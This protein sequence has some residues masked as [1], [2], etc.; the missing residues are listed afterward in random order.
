M[1]KRMTKANLSA[2]VLPDDLGPA[3]GGQQGIIGQ[4]GFNAFGGFVI[5]DVLRELIGKRGRSIFREM[6]DNDSTC[7]ALLFAF[8]TLM[9]SADWTFQA[10]DES[11]A[12]AE[13]QAFAEDVLFG[14][15]DGMDF[16][17]SD[18]LTEAASFLP[19]GWSLQEIIWKRRESDNRIGIKKLA[20]R[21][22]ESIWQWK[23]DDKGPNPTWEVLSAIQQ[24]PSGTLIDLP[25]TKCVHFKT[26]PASGNPEGRSVLR[27]AYRSWSMKK[28]IENIEGIGLERDL[29]GLPMLLVPGAMMAADAD[30]IQKN[31]LTAYKALVRRIRRDSQEGIIL[32][33]NRDQGG[34]LLFELK[35][36]ASAGTRQIDTTKIV[37][38]YAKA[39]AMSVLADFIFLGQQSVGS[40]ALSSDKTE[41]FGIAVSGF[42]D[43]IC[44]A[45]QRQLVTRL[46]EYNGLNPALMPTLQHS[47]VEQTAL[48]EIATLIGA[49][50]GAGAQ[51]FPD[52]ELENVLRKR[53]GLPEAPEEGLG[54][55]GAPGVG[56]GKG[57]NSAGANQND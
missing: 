12:A 16:P 25:L 31:A 45:Y 50:V 48:A 9:N 24:P 57:Q 28:R 54:D 11:N 44:D 36:L 43:V 8:N 46:W 42:L 17:F 23:F 56:P 51:M 53:M 40:F 5:D 32:P 27:G 37:D 39:I 21:R 6:A 30:P 7:S 47:D 52:R 3:G 19:F 22:Q 4:P 34:N 29:A 14:D 2:I 20:G 26:T 38:R 35:L 33:S 41:L 13:A 1:A 18:C 55:Q 10:K 15:D 49:M